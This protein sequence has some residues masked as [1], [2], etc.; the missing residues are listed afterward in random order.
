MKYLFFALSSIF[1]YACTA[2]T[3]LPKDAQGREDFLAFHKKFYEDSIFQLQRIEFPLLKVMEKENTEQLY[4]TAENWQLIKALDPNDADVERQFSDM[5]NVMSEVIIY[6]KQFRINLMYSLVGQK[7]LL[8]S[9]SGIRDLSF[10]YKNSSI[11][12]NK[13]EEMPPATSNTPNLEIGN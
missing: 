13:P 12:L 5:T 2:N 7:W 10:F 1:L 4:W 8:T 3:E 9:Y 6:Q 11:K